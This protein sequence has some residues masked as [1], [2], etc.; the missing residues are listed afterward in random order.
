MTPAQMG[1]TMGLLGVSGLL[2]AIVVPSLSDKFGRKPILYI[3]VSLGI[4]YPLSV[5]FLHGSAIY[6]PALFI[7]YFMMGC[8]PI[9]A[10]VIPSESVPEQLRAKAMGLIMGVGEIVGGVLVPTVAGILSDS[11]APSAFLWVSFTLAIL[12]IGFIFKLKET[13]VLK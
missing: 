4:F 10:A 6:L 2:S 8:I 12:A 7:T 11:I 5:I 13:V 9:V 1:S 3:F